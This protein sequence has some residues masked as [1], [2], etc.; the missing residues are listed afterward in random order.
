MIPL[1]RSPPWTVLVF[2]GGTEIGLEINR[3]LRDAKEVTLLSAGQAVPSAA[4]FRFKRHIDLPAINDP[5]CLGALNAAIVEHGIDAIYPAHDDVVLGLASMASSLNAAVITSP[6]E[7]CAICRSKS[8]T[9]E[10]LA[11]TV[12]VPYVFAR[13]ETPA[14]P[15]FVKPDRGQG[16]SG[17]R[18]IDTQDELDRVLAAEDDLIVSECLIGEEF[19]IDCFS[20][21]A[22]GLLYHSARV[23]TRTRAGIAMQSCLVEDER[24][25]AMARAIGAAMVFHGAWFF[26]A[27]I[28]ANGEFKLLEVA[29][30]VSGTMALSRVLGVNFPLLSLFEAAGLPVNIKAFRGSIEISRSLDNHYRYD[31]SYSAVYIDLDDTLILR[32]YVNTRIMRFIFQCIN[33]KI[34][35]YLLTRHRGDLSNIL[36]RYRLASLFDDVIH[37]LDDSPKGMVIKEPDAIFIDDS[38]RERNAVA[39]CCGI[40]TFDPSGMECLIDER[41]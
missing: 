40:R 12:A 6:L 7:T 23:R 2:P 26:Q 8:A 36:H 25:S 9:Y 17:A 3:A 38:F 41:D 30:R 32:G 27:K 20:D 33:R 1:R 5:R 37:I 21:R 22:R 35:I 19:T 13:G 24:L 18:R 28:A 34:P 16:S 10:A 31:K 14:F 39:E 4:E 29:P 11:G 15:V